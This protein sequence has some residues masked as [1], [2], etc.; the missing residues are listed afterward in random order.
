[1]APLGE[2]RHSSYFTCRNSDPLERHSTEDKEQMNLHHRAPGIASQRRREPISGCVCT[3]RT[4]MGRHPSSRRS[5]LKLQLLVLLL[6][7]RSDHRF[8]HQSLHL[9]ALWDRRQVAV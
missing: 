2:H 4:A 5:A 8:L 3:I 6:L 1:M 7:Q 9:C